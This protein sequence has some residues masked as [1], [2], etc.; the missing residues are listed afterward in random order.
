MRQ[1]ETN[2]AGF[3]DLLKTSMNDV[4]S[5]KK[6]D[7]ATY[8]FMM[9]KFFKNYINENN[10]KYDVE[11][12]LFI[13]NEEAENIKYFFNAMIEIF[14]KSKSVGFIHELTVLDSEALK[15]IGDLQLRQLVDMESSLRQQSEIVHAHTEQMEYFLREIGIKK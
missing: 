1:H 5:F 2:L 4:A 13:K 12:P 15:K 14:E 7:I 3:I 8:F 11:S 9:R 6:E 10:E